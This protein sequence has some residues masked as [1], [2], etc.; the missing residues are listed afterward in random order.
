MSI[1]L[2]PQPKGRNNPNLFVPVLKR[3]FSASEGQ[4]EAKFLSGYDAF[5]VITG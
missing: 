4:Q 3:D 2:Y 5:Q 1:P